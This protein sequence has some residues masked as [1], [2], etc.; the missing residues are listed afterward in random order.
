MS[1]IEFWT[2][3][4]AGAIG[5][6]APIIVAGV[7]EIVFERAGGFNVGIEGMMLLGA[8]T[9]VVGARVGGVWVGLLFALLA[10][11]LA[12]GVLGFAHA[13]VRA[14]IVVVGVAV[15]TITTGLSVFIYQWLSPAGAVNRTVPTQ[16]VLTLPLLEHL[17]LVGRG[18]AHAG[19]FFYASLVLVVVVG[20]FLRNTR[21]GLR[22]TAV[23]AAPEVARDR[24]IS[25][26]ATLCTAAVFAGGCA[27]LGGAVV[28]LGSIGTFSPGMTGGVGFIALAVVIV[29]RG[30]PG[31]LVIGA[32]GFAFFNSLALLAQTRD[33][34]L[35]VEL[36]QGLPYAVA[37]AVLCVAASGRGVGGRLRRRPPPAATRPSG[38]TG[39]TKP[40]VT[41]NDKHSHPD[42]P[43]EALS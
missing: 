41:G 32:L 21:A 36:Y 13:I 2:V 35:P 5:L 22:L 31:G 19:L 18:L 27:G 24:G 6:S 40:P 16:P 15:G 17:P 29:A 28:S 7:G 23:G 10:G 8:A 34:G 12:G 25:P 42:Q 37:L 43:Q 33:L 11:V 14:D 38:N 4:I 3:V 1:A 30:R 9:G 20:W 26:S 39:D